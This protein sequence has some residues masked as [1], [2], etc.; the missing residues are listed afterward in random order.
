MRKKILL[1]NTKDNNMGYEKS[2]VKIIDSL[3]GYNLV[4][5]KYSKYRSWL[6]SF[7]KI[8]FTRFIK[9]NSEKINIIDL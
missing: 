9:R 8:D 7:Y 4:A 1:R 3:Q 2:H 6:D 5:D